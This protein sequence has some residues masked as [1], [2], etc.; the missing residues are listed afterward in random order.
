MGE[1][2][3]V[4]VAEDRLR[5]CVLHGECVVRA[6]PRVVFVGMA[7]DANLRAYVTLCDRL[8]II[9]LPHRVSA[10]VSVREMIQSTPERDR[11]EYDSAPD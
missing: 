9:S 5:I 6:L 7:R 8:K 2:R 4:K 1:L 10:R 3:V 11:H